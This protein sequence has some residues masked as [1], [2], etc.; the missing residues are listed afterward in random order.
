MDI[1][2]VLRL[3][4]D[5]VLVA[6]CLFAFRAGG[7]P[8]KCG[9]TIMLMGSILTLVVEQPSIFD[10]R[11]A[12]GGLLAVDLGVFAAFFTLAQRCKRFWPLWAVAC[13][14]IAIATHLVILMQPRR[15]LQAYAIMQGF[16]AYPMLLAIVIGTEGYR[17]RHRHKRSPAEPAVFPTGVGPYRSFTRLRR[18][19]SRLLP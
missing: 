9:A 3:L 13:H 12:R 16:W 11:F 8:E 15:I 2:L 1:F 6:S 18:R 5:S 4:Y 10:W 14:L 7:R 19:S 17:R